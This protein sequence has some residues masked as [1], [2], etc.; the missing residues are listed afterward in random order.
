MYRIKI[1]LYEMDERLH[2]PEAEIQ[3]GLQ[4]SGYR[5]E[6]APKSLK[7][8]NLDPERIA[9][10]VKEISCDAWIVIAGPKDVLSWF[11]EQPF[12][13]LAI[14]GNLPKGPISG[15]GPCHLNALKE[16]L[17]K[18]II[19]GHEKISIFSRKER[20][21]PNPGVPERQLLQTLEENGLPITEQTFPEWEESLSGFRASLQS[22][23]A[24]SRPSAVIF[25][26]PELVMAAQQFLYQQGMKIPEH[27]SVFCTDYDPRFEWSVPAIAHSKWDFREVVSAAVKWAGNV[28]NGKPETS[29]NILD[30][31]FIAGETIGPPPMAK[32]TRETAGKVW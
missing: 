19:L 26:E 1:L 6:F 13:T 10:F 27:V 2:S 4:Q 7:D 14:F 12:P 5:A 18:L 15:I 22:L 23:F 25:Q 8:L 16:C 29:K 9:S 20:R 17:E 3:L 32:W 31:K 11:A 24:T 30:A 28:S 21:P